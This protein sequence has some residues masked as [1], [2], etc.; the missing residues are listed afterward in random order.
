M[1]GQ[2][3]G[4]WAKETPPHCPT[5]PSSPY[6]PSTRSLMGSEG[7]L[8]IGL[9]EPRR[10]KQKG[11]RAAAKHAEYGGRQV[12]VELPWT[13]DMEALP[14][15]VKTVPARVSSKVNRHPNPRQSSA[16]V[17]AT[18]YAM[19]VVLLQ[20][21]RGTIETPCRTDGSMPMRLFQSGRYLLIHTGAITTIRSRL[22]ESVAIFP[23][24][25]LPMPW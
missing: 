16:T 22:H 6:P 19:R 2:S 11:K 18:E 17:S 21:C 20:P 12:P 14:S 13:V 15:Q 8:E 1:V 25:C 7:P 9:G 3:K 4:A 24:A 10:I 23:R 5:V